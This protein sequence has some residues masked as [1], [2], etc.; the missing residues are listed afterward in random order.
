[1]KRLFGILI[2]LAVIA[3]PA[4]AQKITIDYGSGQK[5][6]HWIGQQID[7]LSIKAGQ[8]VVIAGADNVAW[9]DRHEHAHVLR[10]RTVMGGALND[11]KSRK[12]L[13]YSS[14]NLGDAA[15]P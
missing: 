8:D 13:V 11:V 10:V 14:E 2:G 15:I 9:I 12:F 5:T 4:A 3:T 1:M 7:E 6:Q